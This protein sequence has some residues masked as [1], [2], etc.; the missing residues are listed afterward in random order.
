MH[1]KVV[2][3]GAEPLSSF[4]YCTNVINNLLPISRIKGTDLLFRSLHQVE[5][6]FLQLS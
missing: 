3:T 6:R 5:A 4:K 2:N 1:S